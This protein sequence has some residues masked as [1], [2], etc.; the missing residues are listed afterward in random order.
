MEANPPESRAPPDADNPGRANQDEIASLSAAHDI[1]NAAKGPTLAT[2][3]PVRDPGQQQMS[4][5]QTLESAAE[6][7]TPA[8]PVLMQ[9]SN[10]PGDRS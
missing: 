1:T 6:L 10:H 3:E 8:A 7:Q 2:Q 4:Q 5:D 9:M